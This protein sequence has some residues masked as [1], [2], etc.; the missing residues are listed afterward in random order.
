MKPNLTLAAV[1]LVLTAAF[2][3]P[4]LAADKPTAAQPSQGDQILRQMSA[5]LGGIVSPS[6]SS[7]ASRSAPPPSPAIATRKPSRRALGV[8]YEQ[9]G[10][11]YDMITHGPQVTHGI[12][13]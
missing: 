8:D 11:T 6:H 13:F 5:K 7:P 2:T 12:I 9:N 1:S 10:L 3:P 4:V